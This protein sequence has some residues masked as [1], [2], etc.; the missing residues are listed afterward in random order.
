ME[1]SGEQSC[2]GNIWLSTKL[3]CM[4]WMLTVMCAL[5]LNERPSV[6]KDYND[7][8]PLSAVWSQRLRDRPTRD[9]VNEN[10]LSKTAFP[11]DIITSSAGAVANYCDEYVCL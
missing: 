1:F 2:I 10:K 9:G 4:Q 8:N 11:N 5:I 7:F 6:T 3:Q